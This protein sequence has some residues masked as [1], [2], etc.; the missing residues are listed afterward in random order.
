MGFDPTTMHMLV[1]ERTTDLLREAER[2]RLAMQALDV[3][4]PRAPR[5]RLLPRLSFKLP[6]GRFLVRQRRDVAL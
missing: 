5:R 1:R 6:F 4:P 3:L 2:D